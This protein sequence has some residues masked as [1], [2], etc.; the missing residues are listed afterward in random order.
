M[1]IL[2]EQ[3][4]RRLQYVLHELRHKLNGDKRCEV[5][6]YVDKCRILR[7]TDAISNPGRC[8]NPAHQH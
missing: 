2:S 7:L 1:Q 3:A 5:E 8:S 4:K 6:R